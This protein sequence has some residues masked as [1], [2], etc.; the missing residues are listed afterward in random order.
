MVLWG[1]WNFDVL[2]ENVI[3]RFWWKIWFY[4][5]G[6]KCNFGFGENMIFKYD[7]GS[8]N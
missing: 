3:L 7:F 4:G 6:E 2:R 1:K 8:G 5:F